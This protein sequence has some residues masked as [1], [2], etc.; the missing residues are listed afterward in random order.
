MNCVNVKT[1]CLGGCGVR[2]IIVPKARLRRILLAAALLDL[3]D[4][5][6][7]RY[8]L[9]GIRCDFA[10][11]PAMKSRP[12]FCSAR[13]A[14]QPPTTPACRRLA[15]AGLTVLAMAVRADETEPLP[16]VT[17]VPVEHFPLVTESWGSGNDSTAI[18]AGP[19]TRLLA[20][21]T[22]EGEGRWRYREPVSIRDPGPDTADFPNS[23]FTLPQGGVYVETSPVYF[24]SAVRNVS[25]PTYTWEYLLRFGLTDHVEFRLY[26]NGL[27]VLIPP[28]GAP[29]GTGEVGFSPIVFDS[30]IHFWDQG[31]GGWMPATGIEV[32]VQ[33]DF[34]SP[35]LQQGTQPGVMMLFDWAITERVTFE[36]NA[37]VVSQVTR[38]DT[39]VYTDAIQFSL[40][41]EFGEDLEI[42]IHGFQG[43][44]ALPRGQSESAIGGGFKRVI[45]DRWVLFGSWNAGFEQI[46]PAS[47]FYVGGA[48]SF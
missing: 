45:G 27:T 13:M 25:P 10:P 42:F 29:P 16:P 26:G 44:P 34:G 28:D 48:G 4:E 7:G 31:D 24:E 41:R 17:P 18:G 47:I 11:S 35:S 23:P 3:T 15:A 43:Q 1:D 22:P 8:A 39:L 19:W 37:G 21:L 6:R 36:L 5:Y 2:H 32:Y 20:A 38:T 14:F 9:C 33:S 40:G 30:K 46:G 12:P